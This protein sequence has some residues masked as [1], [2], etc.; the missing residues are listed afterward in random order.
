[1]LLYKKYSSNFYSVII[2][3]KKRELKVN[4]MIFV[5]SA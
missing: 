5:K 2:D 3:L 1:M 4:C